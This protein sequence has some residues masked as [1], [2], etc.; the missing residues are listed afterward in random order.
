MGFLKD[1]RAINKQAKEVSKDW[2]PA[3]QMRQANAMMQQQTAQMKLSASGTPA[4]AIVNALRDT[5]ALVNN[6][7]MVEVDV[8][9]MP[10][11]GAPFPATM[12]VMG[13]A[14]LAGLQQGSTIDVVYDPAQ[15]GVVARR[16]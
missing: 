14:Q 8:T 9:V 13:H 1:L 10:P 11:G 5:G 12:S 3:A 4:T 2:D 16:T 6:Q 7:P 15:P